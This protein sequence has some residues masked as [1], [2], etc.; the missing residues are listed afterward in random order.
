MISVTPG[1]AT[2]TASKTGLSDRTIR[3]E[4]QIGSMPEAVREAAA[5]RADVAR[6]PVSGDAAPGRSAPRYGTEVVLGTK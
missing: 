3:H 5:A 1:F 6:P 2:D 4:V